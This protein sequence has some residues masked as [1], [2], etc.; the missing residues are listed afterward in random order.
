VVESALRHRESAEL[1]PELSQDRAAE[2][3]VAQ[4]V[5]E[6][7][8]ASDDLALHTESRNAVGEHLLSLRKDLKDRPA[9]RLK[10]AALGLIESAQVLVNLR[11]RHEHTVYA[12]RSA[13]RGGST[14]L[15]PREYRS[16]HGNVLGMATGTPLPTLPMIVTDPSDHERRQR[17]TRR[18]RRLTQLGLAWHVVEAATAVAAGI[19]AGSVALVGFGADS[20]IEAGAGLVV[21]WP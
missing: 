15:R 2:R 10:R 7:G 4:V 5:L 6:R 13:H 18:A 16:W 1:I 3:Q 12:A 20:V 11:R 19:V 8:E 21:L 17:L 9:Q 14:D